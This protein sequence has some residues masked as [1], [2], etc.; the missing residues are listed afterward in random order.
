MLM[1]A[2]LDVHPFGY[3]PGKPIVSNH[4]DFLISANGNGFGLPHFRFTGFFLISEDWNSRRMHQTFSFFSPYD[5]PPA[6]ILARNLS[7][8]YWTE[9]SAAEQPE[10]VVLS[11]VAEPNP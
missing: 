9:T 4:E 1:A 2:W 10:H 8:N 3:E 11:E 5:H 6:G 7:K